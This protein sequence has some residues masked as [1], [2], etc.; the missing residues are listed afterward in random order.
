MVLSHRMGIEQA[1]SLE[2]LVHSSQH[3]KGILEISV[4]L[5][6]TTTARRPYMRYKCELNRLNGVYK[7][8][9]DRYI[10]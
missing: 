9:V 8:P 2:V 5:S 1:T 4:L 6:A 7:A 3:I 10:I